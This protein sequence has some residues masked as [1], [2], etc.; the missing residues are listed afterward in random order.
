MKTLVIS[1][2][3]IISKLIVHE[4]MSPARE[5]AVCETVD[6]V[7]GIIG[8]FLPDII[9]VSTDIP[10][11][12]VIMIRRNNV[13]MPETSVPVPVIAIVESND[14]KIIDSVRAAG[15][16]RIIE[17][18]FEK[19]ELV[20][21]VSA[22]TES[23]RNLAGSSV[24][25]VD[26]AKFILKV[27]TDALSAHGFEVFTAENGQQAWDFLNS[28]DDKNIDIVI[29]DL[30]MPLMNGEELCKKIRKHKLF[31]R[32]P[33]V[34]MTSEGGEETEIRMLRAGA[35]DFISKPFLKDLLIARV[36]VHLEG[37]LLAKNLNDLVE[38]RTRKF[39]EAKVAA[40]RAASA[41][42]QF[43]ANMSHEIRTPINGIIGFTTMVLDMEL[44]DEQREFLGTVNQCS[45]TLLSL[46]NDI[47]DLTKI[48]SGKIELETIEF[49][50]ENLLYKV[51]DMI[52]TKVSN[53]K[54][55]LLVEIEDD[56]YSVVKGDPTRL[57][58]IIV[59]QLSN[60]A[61]FT[62]E[63]NIIVHAKNISEE[64]TTVTVEISIQDT[65]IGMSPAQAAKIFD[66]FTQ[67]DGSTT[68]KFGG[69]GLGLTISK[70]L[71]SLMGGELK[72]ESEPGVGS[73][74]YFTAVLEKVTES[75]KSETSHVAP[76][77]H[78]KSCLIVDDNPDALRILSEIVKRIGMFPKTANSAAKALE[79]SSK[80]DA[81][82]LSDIM[83]PGI[84]GYE[85]LKLM[86]AKYQDETPPAIVITADTKTNVVK[87]IAEGGFAGYLFK[88]VRRHALVR[89]IHKVLDTE[90]QEDA[91][92]VLTEQSVSQSHVVSLNILVAEDNRVN[93]MLAQKMLSKM[94]H[95]PTI[96]ED[97]AVAFEMVL[98]GDYDIIFMD[99]QMPVMDGVEA[100]I[101][102]REAG[103]KT[104]V[105]A[106]TANV[107][108]S[109]REACREAGMDDFIPKPVKRELVR[110]ILH[111]YCAAAGSDTVVEFKESNYRMLIV[112]DNKTAA[113][114][115]SKN[116]RKHFPAWTIQVANDGVEASVLL[117]S[118]KPMVVL[119]DIM[120]PN[121]DGLALVR[122]IKS[123]ENYSNTKIIIMSSLDRN[124]K[125]VEEIQELGVFAIEPKPC[126]FDVLKK[127][128]AKLM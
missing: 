89:M 38:A 14:D 103:I 91:R 70:R 16:T 94:G 64:D 10:A 98:S 41:K 74:F 101:K 31:G 114:I 25:V 54:V 48:E 8:Q 106:M 63:G 109:D 112:E 82:I 15:V 24:L 120:M 56:V 45:E 61:K 17:S 71:A 6:N 93:Q 126:K 21:T 55:D 27:A 117:G 77:L 36:S 83:M 96:A 69:T 116:I 35:S 52:R 100:T 86:Q 13:F 42:S 84:D 123:S 44:S 99:M 46:I 73:R 40:E 118:F 122:F 58:Q 3:K 29:T 80:D 9:V 67:A 105:I 62:E 128:L 87:Q 2:N 12:I 11:D 26:D 65:G 68:R 18:P 127:H 81:I 47:L 37:W 78:G 59:N 4:L 108:E 95:H 110:D 124:D 121:M 51:C 32:I 75:F 60:A 92:S 57:S 30:H 43:L 119:S 1:D 102:L 39:L 5:V 111:R 104:P 22:V 20:D 33:V 125:R 115:I 88:P 113:K 49:N 34:F 72:V 28:D 90:V 97:G 19:S 23:K 7:I 50:F 85:F 79:I 53:E 107:F 66:P 76:D